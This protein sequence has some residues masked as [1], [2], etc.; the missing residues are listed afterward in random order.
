MKRLLTAFFLCFITFAIAKDQ[1]KIKPFDREK[2]NFEIKLREF[3]R[4]S[5]KF[6]KKNPFTW[7]EKSIDIFI[8]VVEKDLEVLPYTIHY[9]RKN[10][11][12]PIKNVYIVAPESEKIRDCAK[13]MGCVFIEENTVL[14]FTM[15]DI[16]YFPGNSDRRGWLFQQLLKLNADEICECENILILDA[17]TLLMRPQSFFYKDQ[18][19]LNNSEECY[20]PYRVMYHDLIQEEAKGDFSFV[21]HMMLFQKSKLNDLKTHVENVHGKI[22]YEAI[23]DLIDKNEYSAFSEYETYGQF[24]SSRYK[25]EFVQLYFFNVGLLREKSLKKILMGKHPLSKAIKSCSFHDWAEKK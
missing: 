16:D 3:K 11:L 22:W 13:Q 24:V 12:H 1:V 10:L 2:V 6:E 17:D 15:Q 21:T 19:I 5:L 9:A 14:P 25:E 7:S 20:Y 18:V 4:Q 23:F 8:P